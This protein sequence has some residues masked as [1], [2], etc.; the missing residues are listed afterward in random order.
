MHISKFPIYAP[1]QQLCPDTS[2]MTELW[3]TEENNRYLVETKLDD[4]TRLWI[5]KKCI[6]DFS[7][8]QDSKFTW[9]IKLKLY[10]PCFC[11]YFL[12]AVA[13]VSSH[14]WSKCFARASGASWNCYSGNKIHTETRHVSLS[15]I[16]QVNFEFWDLLKIS[17]KQSSVTSS[18]L[19]CLT[20]GAGSGE[21]AFEQHMHVVR[22]EGTVLI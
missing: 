15:F 12:A 13:I 10:I 21:K 19:G 18:S 7:R 6:G 2:C 1:W 17:N 8:S 9:I 4:V 20:P 14:S 16:I 22:C 11:V 5:A 3:D